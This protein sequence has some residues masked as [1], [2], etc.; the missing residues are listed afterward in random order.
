MSQT[1]H[2][3]PVELLTGLVESSNTMTFLLRLSA[4]DRIRAGTL[5]AVPVHSEIL[6][7][8]TIAVLTRVSR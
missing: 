1:E 4:E 5:A 8:G 6:D 7:M 3:H 2:L